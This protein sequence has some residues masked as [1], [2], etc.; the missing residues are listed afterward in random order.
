LGRR[1]GLWRRLPGFIRRSSW[2]QAYGSHVH[3]LVCLVSERTQYH[4]TY[5]LRNGVE[6][7]LIRRLVDQKRRGGRLNRAVLGY[8]KRAEAY[9]IMSVIRSA[10]P[11]WGLAVSAVDISQEIVKFA[12]QGIYFLDCPD[13]LT[14]SGRTSGAVATEEVAKNTHRDQAGSMFERM[15]R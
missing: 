2:L 10:R 5:L 9:S 4:S 14:E 12:E 15:P 8:S 6:L 11:D 13:L 7:E 3:A 1:R